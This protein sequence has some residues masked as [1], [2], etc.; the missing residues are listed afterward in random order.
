MFERFYWHYQSSDAPQSKI[1]YSFPR[2]QR[3]LSTQYGTRGPAFAAFVKLIM[4]T[5]SCAGAGSWLET[6]R[7]RTSYSYG[8]TDAGEYKAAVRIDLNSEF[9][10]IRV[11][12]LMAT[13][14]VP[15]RLIKYP[16][17]PHVRKTGPSDVWEAVYVLNSGGE[18]WFSFS[19]KECAW[20]FAFLPIRS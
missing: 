16:P 5:C 17:S 20:H 3:G 19:T 8:T 10:C 12:D 9:A 7:T 14:G 13:L 1:R 18:S 11:E 6:R 4:L 15:A 2:L